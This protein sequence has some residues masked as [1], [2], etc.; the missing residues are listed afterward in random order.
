MKK[1]LSKLIILALALSVVAFSP[2]TTLRVEA[3]EAT[4]YHSSA[5]VSDGDI[6]AYA[7]RIKGTS[8][9][10]QLF[11]TTPPS[12]GN[13]ETLTL[14]GTPYY[15]DGDKVRT[16]V[17][18][19]I[20]GE[21]VSKDIDNMVV[22]LGIE[23]DLGSASTLMSGVVPFVNGLLGVICTVISIGM[24]IF[25]ALDVAYIIAPQ[26]K[27]ACDN[28]AASGNKMT[29]KTDSTTGAPRFRWITDKAVYAIKAANTVETGKQALWIYLKSRVV[30]FVV[31]AIVLYIL[32]T[33]NIGIFMNLG[34]KVAD[35]IIQL[36]DAV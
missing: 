27:E 21:S 7:E 4:S 5:D 13:Y 14:D 18:K 23:A 31:L 36:I 1:L 15:Y 24:F 10:D 34:L 30:E 2:V 17:Y 29:S 12:S 33:G 9:F 35:G 20:K 16:A 19:E 3:S 28:A 11:S 26:F 8:K 32:L 6:L 25:T 22:D